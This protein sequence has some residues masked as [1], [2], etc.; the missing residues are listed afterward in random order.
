MKFFSKVKEVFQLDKIDIFERRD[1][2]EASF[3][4][5]FGMLPH[6]KSIQSLCLL[7]PKRDSITLTLKNDSE[8]MICI[9]EHN[10][11]NID[12]SIL[13]SNLEEEDNISVTIQIDKK[14]SDSKFSIYDFPRFIEDLLQLSIL[15][16]LSWFSKKLYTQDHLIFEVFDYNISFSTKTMAFESYENIVFTPKIDRMQ[17]IKNCK[18]TSC[19]YDMN[20]FEVIPEDFLVE[21]IMKSDNCLQTDRLKV[22]FGKL[23]TILSLTY[24]ATSSS[25]NDG[26]INLEISGQNTVGDK[27][28]ICNIQ[29]DKKWQKIYMWIFTDGNSID[30]ALIARN[31]ISLHCKFKKL[32]DLD[33]AVFESIKTNYSLYLKK[34]VNQYIEMKRDIAKFIQNVVAQVGDYAVAMLGKFKANLIA[35]FGFLFTVVLTRIGGVQKWDEIFTQDTIYLI[36][37]FV[38]GSLV[39][40]LI[41]FFEMRFKLKKIKQSYFELK[42]NY[43]DV[44]SAIEIKEAF[45]NDELL[46]NTE[47]SAKSGIIGWSLAW[48]LLL[49]IAILAIELFATDHGIIVWAWNKIFY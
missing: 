25:I 8:D 35:I 44:L 3:D 26:I 18:D 23:S 6:I 5:T 11:E 2:V 7:V 30:K 37:L 22:I 38:I 39:Y 19:F 48:G 34:N 36:E 31:A 4:I 20:T 43:E 9:T 10:I 1:T 17:H 42:K 13:V 12:L 32:S 24:I 46:N 41:C 14:V 16:I 47:H 15:D 40:L 33:D 45:K 29:E 21:G 28:Q 27:L 49:I